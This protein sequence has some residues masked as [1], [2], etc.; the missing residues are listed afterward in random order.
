MQVNICTRLIDKM[1]KN[2]HKFV[3]KQIILTNSLPLGIYTTQSYKPNEILRVMSGKMLNIATQNSIH[4]GDN[5]HLEDEIGQYIN[6]SFEPNI[7]IVG[8]KLVAIKYINMYEE[9]TFNYNENE[10]E[11]VCPFEDNGIK[12]CGKIV[13]PKL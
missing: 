10:L 2:G 7:K 1:I 9:I 8:N 5:M 4:I 6:H 11:M 12:V 3:N 13:K